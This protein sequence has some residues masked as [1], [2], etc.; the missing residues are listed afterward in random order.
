VA[1]AHPG[2]YGL[3]SMRSRAREICGDFGI[4]SVPGRG[5]LVRV[6]VPVEIHG[7]TGAR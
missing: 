1:L 4:N 6:E 2:H 5:T 3:E 7:D